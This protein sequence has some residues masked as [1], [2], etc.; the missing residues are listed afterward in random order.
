M[1]VWGSR[2]KTCQGKCGIGNKNSLESC[3]PQIATENMDEQRGF[4]DLRNLV[5]ATYAPTSDLT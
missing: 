4:W 3:L 5:P 1:L 2:Y